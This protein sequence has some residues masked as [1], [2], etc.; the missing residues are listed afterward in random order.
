MHWDIKEV[1]ASLSWN[2][3]YVIVVGFYNKGHKPVGGIMTFYY[4][5]T[6]VCKATPRKFSISHFP[7]ICR[8]SSSIIINYIG[9]SFTF[10]AL[11]SPVIAEQ[12]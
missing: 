8:F 12:Y 1:A 3:N 5:N 11:F 6:Y 10:C 2:T 7:P 4:E 9:V